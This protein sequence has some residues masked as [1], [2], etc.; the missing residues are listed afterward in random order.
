M[1]MLHF[2]VCRCWFRGDKGVRPGRLV[3][4]APRRR[5][6]GGCHKHQ[7]DVVDLDCLQRPLPGEGVIEMMLVGRR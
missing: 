7:E 5:D 1:P 6:H 4:Q 2:A 3:Y